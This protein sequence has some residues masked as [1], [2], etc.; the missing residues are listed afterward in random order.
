VLLLNNVKGG[1]QANLIIG[2]K[3]VSQQDCVKDLGVHVDQHLKYEEH[4]NHIV[5]R[6]NKVPNLIYKCFVSQSEL[7]VVY[8][9][10][11]L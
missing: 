1:H 8:V 11:A 6:A 4:V 7:S 2:D 3:E 10:A 9:L 5:A